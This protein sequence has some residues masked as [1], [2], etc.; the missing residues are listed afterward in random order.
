M[1]LP[2][3]FLQCI[4][5]SS[6]P[7]NVEVLCQTWGLAGVHEVTVNA[8]LPEYKTKFACPKGLVL[9]NLVSLS[10][11]NAGGRLLAT[12]LGE[13]HPGECHNGQ[14]LAK[15]SLA[16]LEFWVLFGV[17]MHTCTQRTL[18][19]WFIGFASPPGPTND[20]LYL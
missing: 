5:T 6:L 18:P 9:G 1:D 12:S 19:W 8:L 20:H 7:G 2:A 11:L 15:T 17:H 10:R 3:T 16:G 13:F 4:P 14:W